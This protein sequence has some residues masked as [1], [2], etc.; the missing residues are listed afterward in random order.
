MSTTTAQEAAL[1]QP[2]HQW[3]TLWLASLGGALEFYD[4]VIFVFFTGVIGKLFF[5]ADLPDWVR[6]LQVF[7]IFAA[8]YIMRPLGGIVMAHFGDKRGRKQMFMLSVLLMAA[9][10][11]AIGLLPTYQSIGV[12]APLLLLAMRLIQ[13]IAIG[14]EAPGGWVFVAE[15]AGHGRSG[16][17]V[18]L[19]TSGLTL[20]IFL[21]SLIATLMNLSFTPTQIA[22]GW[23]RLPFLIG[24]VFGFIAMWLRRWLAETPVFEAMHKRAALS[25]DVPLMVVFKD[26]RR[27]VLI[28]FACTWTLT[29]GLVVLILMTPALL[30]NSF[31]LSPA[32]TQIA[33]LAGTA[34]LG[35]S[36]LLVGIAADRFGIR[37]VAIPAFG[38]MIA[39]TY[40]LYVGAARTPDALVPLYALAGLGAG[41]VVLTPIVMVRLF[42][43]PVRFSGVSLSY[44]VPYALIGGLTPLLV[45]WLS[46]FDR[47]APAHYVVAT[48]FIGAVAMLAAPLRDRLEA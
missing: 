48:I 4:F 11:L 44:N 13:G 3:R 24:G 34:A 7:G 25:K 43:S 20:G 12:A 16:L 30:Q 23:W 1:L 36:T 15:H 47:M 31:G 42:P 8:G 19:L 17:A 33:N 29:A 14:G 22:S 10:T 6:Q 9:P 38:L 27:A 21:G 2:A 32:H 46:H 5:A 18:G 28:S 41:A 37:R 40:A 26:H 39:G 35:L 45:A